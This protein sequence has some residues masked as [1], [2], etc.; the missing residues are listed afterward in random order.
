MKLPYI[1]Q[2]DNIREMTQTI[3]RILKDN[4]VALDAPES[5]MYDDMADYYD[6][7]AE[8]YRSA[9]DEIAAHYGIQHDIPHGKEFELLPTYMHL[10]YYM[11]SRK[12]PFANAWNRLMDKLGG[13]TPVKDDLKR[14]LNK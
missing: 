4:H 8:L 1:K 3:T 7:F 13:K 14:S 2:M 9:I 5:N 11:Y 10:H 6:D 12:Y